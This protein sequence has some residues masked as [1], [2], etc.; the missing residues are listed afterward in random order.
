MAL[1]VWRIAQ[2]FVLTRQEKS[3]DRVSATELYDVV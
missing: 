2:I 1:C 3:M